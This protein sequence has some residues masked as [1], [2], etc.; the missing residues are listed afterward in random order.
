MRDKYSILSR[1]HEKIKQGQ[2]I[3]GTGAGTGLSAKA[4]AE[5]GSDLIIAYSTGRFRMAGRSSMAG[6]FAFSNANSSLLEMLPQLIPEVG[7]VPIIAGVF[8]QDPFCNMDSLLNEIAASGCVG[9]QNIP[10]M[11]GQALMEGELA[12]TQLSS[13]GYGFNAEVD[14]IK[15]AGKRGLLTTPYCSQPEH[16]EKM[17]QAGADIF[18]LHMGLTGSE[19][20]HSMAVTPLDECAD[21]INVLSSMVQRIKPDSIVLAHGGPIVGPEELAYLMNKCPLLHGFYG[22][23]SIERIPVETQ[24]CGTI[25]RFKSLRLNKA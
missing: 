25:S 19:R 17:A 23:S 3:I 20:D 24:V 7:N 1:L 21:K 2:A 6:R 14:F 13:V 9:V 15:K 11:G 10:G 18:V 8:V 5:G 16:I 12:Y 22:A 4:E